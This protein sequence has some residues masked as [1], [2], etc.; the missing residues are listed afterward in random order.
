MSKITSKLFEPIQLGAINAKNRIF[1]AP[2]TRGRATK[3]HVPT[4]IMIE[5][6]KQRASAGLLI[7]EATGI[8][9]QGLGW[10]YAPGI[11]TEEQVNAWKPVTEAVHKAGGKIILQLWHMGRMVHSSFLGGEKPISSS[12]INAVDYSGFG[13]TPVDKINPYKLA[14]TYYGRLKYDEPR[15]ATKADIQ[16][17]IEDYRRAAKNAMAAGFDGVQI[18]AANGY[19]IDQFL[20]DGPNKRTDEYGGSLENRMRLLLEVTQAV[21]DTVGADKTGVRLSPNE[22]AQG[23][24]DSNPQETF[25]AAAKALSELGIAHLEVREPDFHGTFGK[26]EHAPIAPAMRA[27]FKGH[28]VLNSDYT[29]EKADKIMKEG[30]ADAIAFGRPFMANPDLPERFK[31]GATLNKDHMPTWFTQGPEGYTDYPF[32]TSQQSSL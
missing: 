28:F 14:H 24:G 30:L 8:S 27:A 9:Q 1:M 7:T 5:Y 15:A 4:P 18:H 10:P 32:L 26:A 31:T 23:T 29:F 11:W 17:I 13:D 12:A 6:Y 21:V 20:R 2:C 22:T 3:E 19:L 16:A 25:P